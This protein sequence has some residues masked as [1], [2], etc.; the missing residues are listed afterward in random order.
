[1]TRKLSVIKSHKSNLFCGTFSR[2]IEYFP[3]ELP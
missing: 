1:M 2:K 3:G